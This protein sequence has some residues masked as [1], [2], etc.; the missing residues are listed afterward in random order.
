MNVPQKMTKSPVREQDLVET[1]LDIVSG[2]VLI[3]VRMHVSVCVCV[4]VSTCAQ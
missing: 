2:C 4:C 3:S 1:V